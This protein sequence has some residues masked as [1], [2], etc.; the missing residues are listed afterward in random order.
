MNNMAKLYWLKLYY[1]ILDDYK[2]GKLPDRLWR[3]TLELFLLAGECNQKGVLPPVQ[4]MAWRL[5]TSR[6][7]LQK[8]LEEIVTLTREIDL[9]TGA[10]VKP[11][12]IEK[13]DDGWFVVNFTKRQG[14]M[15]KAEYMRRK[16][17]EDFEFRESEKSGT[18]S[19]NDQEE[20]AVI[21]DARQDH[22]EYQK[23]WEQE[24]GMMVTGFAEFSRMCEQFKKVGVTPEIYRTAIQEQ[25][26]S[27]Y[28]VKRP[29]S[30]EAWAV[31][32]A[33]GGNKP[34]GDVQKSNEQIIKEMTDAEF[35]T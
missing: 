20:D 2:M 7:A 23:A 27:D 13:L 11:G 30:V 29:T 34:A 17:E 9:D 16:R 22:S 25:Q 35:G 28:A 18:D 8:E 10:I 6:Q 14:P 4:E 1:E 15:A 32:I 5:R 31:R 24:T 19:N 3:R 26:Q 33:K 21:A 12:I